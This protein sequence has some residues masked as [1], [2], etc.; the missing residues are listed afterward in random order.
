MNSPVASPDTRQP[1]T[2]R[3]RASSGLA[4]RRQKRP[5]QA[6]SSTSSGGAG[7]SARGG[8][9]SSARRTSAAAS[10]AG[11][12]AG[13]TTAAAAAAGAGVG[14]GANA[15][16]TSGGASGAG[17]GGG[18]NASATAAGASGAGAGAGT[19]ASATAAG[20]SGAGAGAGTNASATAASG[21]G[22]GANAS[23]A[24]AAASGAG[25]DANARTTAAAA[26]AA[27]SASSG[28]PEIPRAGAAAVAAA[29]A[30]AA[31][32]RENPGAWPVNPN[33]PTDEEQLRMTRAGLAALAKQRRVRQCGRCRLIG[34]NRNSPLYH[35]QES[36]AA[37]QTRQP[38]SRSRTQTAPSASV[39]VRVVRRDGSGSEADSDGVG[40]DGADD[41]DDDDEEAVGVG[42]AGV[43]NNG[44]V[45]G[46]DILT[47]P[48]TSTD[49]LS[50]LVPH[51]KCYAA[52]VAVIDA[53][54]DNEWERCTTHN[55]HQK[56]VHPF[57]D[58]KAG[59]RDTHAIDKRLPEAER[60]SL[61]WFRLLWTND[62]E[63]RVFHHTVQ[64][65]SKLGGPDNRRGDPRTPPTR[66]HLRIFIAFNIMMGIVDLPQVKQYW[67]MRHPLFDMRKV[68][69]C[70]S[71]NRFA[72]MLAH[73]SFADK[74]SRPAVNEPGYDKLYL[75]R[76]FIRQYNAAVKRYFYPSRELAFDEGPFRFAGMR[77][78]V[79]CF[80]ANCYATELISVRVQVV[81]LSA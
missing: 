71:H 34:H 11:S 75:V 77:L 41:D 57:D 13:S 69:H 7:S 81:R 14:A 70:M 4:L 22:S 19:S 16:T 66:N 27:S 62:F 38:R 52:H 23:A 37:R 5:R 6:G 50:G 10:G 32:R 1:A 60:T 18:T 74:F 54:K 73:I 30:A 40:D 59:L 80:V 72:S 28:T 65:Y 15:R 8:A 68:F 79:P 46:A 48:R 39:G 21:A 2:K 17:S 20:A 42:H 61:D 35:R 9:E 44:A 26:A 58:T 56:T 33:I 31:A 63:R 67:S 47:R 53:I 29:A 3:A 43:S 36:D 78:L 51:N 25:S 45:T 49:F 12:G 24:A 76:P 64:H 55:V